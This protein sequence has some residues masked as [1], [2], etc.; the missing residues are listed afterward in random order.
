MDLMKIAKLIP[1]FTKNEVLN[2]LRVVGLC[3]DSGR[4]KAITHDLNVVYSNYLYGHACSLS[5]VQSKA[6]EIST[7]LTIVSKSAVRILNKMGTD[8]AIE[9]IE[10][11]NLEADSKKNLILEEE[12]RT[13][14]R[15]ILEKKLDEKSSLQSGFDGYKPREFLIDGVTYIDYRSDEVLKDAM[16]GLAYIASLSSIAADEWSDKKRSQEGD[17]YLPKLVQSLEQIWLDYVKKAIRAGST[18]SL[19]GRFILNLNKSIRK[20][21]PKEFC[22]AHPKLGDLLSFSYSTLKKCITKNRISPPRKY[23]F[24]KDARRSL[25][26]V[27]DQFNSA[28]PPKG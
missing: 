17:V 28:K 13:L 3:L 27:F 24:Q 8:E 1:E 21:F 20:K 5:E 23:V 10:E 9:I 2:E 16:R 25:N 18:P 14:Y 6:S 11:H 15:N 22:N 12:T 19:F 26:S 4:L 7:D